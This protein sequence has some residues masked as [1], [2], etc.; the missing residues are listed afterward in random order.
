MRAGE[1]GQVVY[2]YSV[3]QTRLSEGSVFSQLKGVGRL[4]AIASLR[5][6]WPDPVKSG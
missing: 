6:A 5:F 1:R 4:S 2:E 3:E